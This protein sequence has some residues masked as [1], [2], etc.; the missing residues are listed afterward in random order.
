MNPADFVTLG[1]TLGIPGVMI[2]VWYLLEKQ[3]GDRQ[4]TAEQQKIAAEAETQ[5][6]RTAAEN[7]RTDAMEEGFRALASMV[8]D[9]AQA[10]T[11]SHAKQGERLAAIE[12]TLAMR[13]TPPQGTPIPHMPPPLPIRG[14][15]P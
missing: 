14:R 11:D 12:A 5:K 6:Q 10:D 15:K 3:R 4:A 7:R 2:L 9:H 1:K 13:K 8:A